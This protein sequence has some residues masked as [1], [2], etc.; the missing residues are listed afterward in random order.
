MGD[1]I[2]VLNKGVVQQI[3]TPREIYDE[4]VNTFVATFLGSPP[5]NLVQRDGLIVGFR[6]EHFLPTQLYRAGDFI[7]FSFRIH[8]VEY[9]GAERILYG[10]LDGGRFE[11][12]EVVSRIP[13]T[14]PVS[15]T[16][17][18]VNQFGL[19]EKNL[20]FFDRASHQRTEAKVLAW[21]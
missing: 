21:Q 13:S 16:V 17:G 15:Y 12:K 5:M 9:L 18:S 3:G 1:R 2:V 7:P 20:K 8:N 11:H 14:I 6:P 19:R 10:Y 4:P